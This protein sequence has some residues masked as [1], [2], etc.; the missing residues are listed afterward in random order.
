[1]SGWSADVQPVLVTALGYLRLVNVVLALAGVWLVTRMASGHWAE[2]APRAKWLTYSLYV[3]LF[4]A[5]YG[6]LEQA[7]QRVPG[8]FRSVFVT[9]GTICIMR[10]WYASEEIFHRG[11]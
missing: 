10:A 9:A 2:Y 8:S 7:F 6:S 11:D 1:M 3:L 5:A 4:A